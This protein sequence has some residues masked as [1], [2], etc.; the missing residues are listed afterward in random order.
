M[1]DSIFVGSLGVYASVKDPF[2]GFDSEHSVSGL[3]LCPSLNAKAIK[4]SLFFYSCSF[5]CHCQVVEDILVMLCNSI[6]GVY[7]V[8]HMRFF[9]HFNWEKEEAMKSN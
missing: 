8:V 5:G 1:I 4:S 9:Y 7:C 6:R 2:L 3:P